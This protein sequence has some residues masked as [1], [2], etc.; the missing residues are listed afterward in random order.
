MKYFVKLFCVVLFAILILAACSK[1]ITEKSYEQGNTNGNIKQM[2][3]AVEKDGWIYYCNPDGDGSYVVRDGLFKKKVD[4]TDKQLLS[5]NLAYEINIV[6]NYIYYISG[7]PGPIYKIHKNGGT[8]QKLEGKRSNNLIVLDDTVFYRSGK[9]LFKMRT[10]GSNKRKINDD[11]LEFS[12]YDNAIYLTGNDSHHLYR[13]DF[14]G[15]NMQKLS[16]DYALDLNI[17]D[18]W[19]YYVN[20]ND[21]KIYKMK[22]DGTEKALVCADKAWNVNLHEGVLYYRGMPSPLDMGIYKINVDGTGK[23]LIVKGNIGSPNII[24]DFIIYHDV[25]ADKSE[26]KLFKI[27]LD[28]TG[29]KVWK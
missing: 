28:G 15:N 26:E 14:D 11:T 3:Y 22:I 7:D 24:S 9:T 16:D 13:I 5:A 25:F 8:P 2:G 17:A 20:F 18:G 1:P 29:K 6:G 10:N 12:I 23:K 27:N 21:P 4:G 19:I